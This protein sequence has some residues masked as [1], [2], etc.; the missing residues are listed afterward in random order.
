MTF[1]NR[2]STQ[3]ACFSLNKASFTM[4]GR[5]TDYKKEYETQV[6]KLC[7]LGATD[8]EIADFFGIRESTLNN[9]KK[10]HPQFMESIKKGKDMADATVS[11]SLY[12]RANGYSHK[13]TDIRV[14]DEKVVK[15]PLT[16]HYPPDTAAAIFWL[17]NRQS[18]KWRDKINHEHEGAT[19]VHTTVSLTAEEIKS[20]NKEL[21]EEY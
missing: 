11:E 6:Y 1:E 3:K 7:L 19:V 2:K 13:D 5:P 9:W 8:V 14:I 12:K 10:K 17:K 21:E 4:A 16:K 15:T 18:K 20:F